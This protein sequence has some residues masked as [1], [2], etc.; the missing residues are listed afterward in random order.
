MAPPLSAE[1][2][3]GP[4]VVE[5]KQSGGLAWSVYRTYWFAVGGVLAASIMMS[6]LLMQGLQACWGSSSHLNAQTRVFLSDRVRV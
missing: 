4:S 3:V 1:D 6:L 2:D 5:Q